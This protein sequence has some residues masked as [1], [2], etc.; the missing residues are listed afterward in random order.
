MGKIS[1]DTKEES[2]PERHYCSRE[3]VRTGINSS[4]ATEKKV[5]CSK[6][7]AIWRPPIGDGK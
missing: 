2:A 7:K 6:R 5:V 3:A 1:D 4:W